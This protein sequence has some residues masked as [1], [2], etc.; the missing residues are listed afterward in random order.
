MVLRVAVRDTLRV[1]VL[2]AVVDIVVVLLEL[3]L[4][5]TV[6]DSVQLIDVVAV[7]DCERVGVRDRESVG[8]AVLVGVRL[9]VMLVVCDRDDVSVLVIVADEV[10]VL[11]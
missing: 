1:S 6:D 8:V 4:W 2:L 11:L 9:G 3:W 7:H 5:E 10:I